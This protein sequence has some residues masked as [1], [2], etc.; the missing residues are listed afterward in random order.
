MNSL[1]KN[2][3]LALMLL[4]QKTLQENA[5]GYKF[6]DMTIEKRVEF[7]KEM[8]IHATQEIHEM[9]YELPHFKPWKDYSGMTDDEKNQ[10]FEKAK[11]EF[12]DF[13]HFTLNMA[14]ALG[15]TSDDILEGYSA[16]NQEN[17]QR[18]TEGYTHDKS[19][20]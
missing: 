5:Y 4:M 19:Y 11:G 13:M 17:Y 2:D 15:L 3:N 20:R 7:I 12:V 9:L 6:A 18:Q 1:T 16:K 8:S 14:L 10:A